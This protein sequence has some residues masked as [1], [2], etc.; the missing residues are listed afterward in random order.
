M[1]VAPC[2][3]SALFVAALLAAE[4]P[5]KPTHKL[6]LADYFGPFLAKKLNDCRTCHLPDT[7]D[8]ESEKPH[9]AFGAKLAELRAKLKQ[10]GKKYDIPICLEAIAN[11][12]SDGDGVS[13]IVELLSGHFPGDA[14]DKPTAEEIAKIEKTLAAFRK[15]QAGYPWRPFEPVNRP[16]IPEVKN[17][18]WVRN[19]IDAFITAGHEQEGITPRPEAPRPVLLRRVYLDLFGLPPTR[20]ELRAFLND[21]SA[22][23]YEKVVERLLASPQYGERWGRHWMD[24][25]RYSDWAG[26]GAEV[27]DSQPHVWRWRDWIVESLNADKGYDRMIQEMLAGDELAPEDPDI[28]R[29]TGYLVRNYK[30]YSR[31]RWMQDTVEHTFMAFQAVTLQCAR[32][33]DHMYDPIEQSEYYGVRA[34]FEPYQVRIDRLPGQPDLAKDGLARAYDADLK[35]ITYLFVRGDDR[36]PDKSKPLEPSVPAALGGKLATEPV[37]LPLSAHTPD[38][39][40]FVMRELVESLEKSL[41]LHDRDVTN[42]ERAPWL[43]HL[44]LTPNGGP[45]AAVARLGMQPGV[46]ALKQ[47]S[48]MAREAGVEAVR[49]NRLIA[50]VERLEDAGRSG[51]PEWATVAQDLVASERRLAHLTARNR[52]FGFKNGL[53][54]PDPKSKSTPQQQLAEAEKG[55][56]KAEAELKLPPSTQYTKRA[57]TTYPQTS[58]GRRLAFARWLSDS[59]NPLTARVAA[60]HIWLRHFGSAIAPSVFDFGKNGRLPSHPA[61]LDWLA[62]ELMSPTTPPDGGSASAWSMKHLHRLIVTS[63][64]YRQGSTPEPGNL[65]KDPDNIYYWRMLPHRL[66]AEVVRDSVFFVAGRLDGRMGGPDLDHALGLTAPR[67]SLYFRHAAEKQMEFLKLFDA[68]SVTEC[69][70]RR[71]SIMPQQALALANSGLVIEHARILA[72][73]L[74][75]ETGSDNGA[76]V[77]AAFETVLARPATEA[78][79]A[80]C[81]AFLEKQTQTHTLSADKTADGA[82]PG[83]KAPS[84]EPATRARENLV[85]VLM[86]HHDFVTVR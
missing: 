43:A 67:R 32:C 35:A 53:T 72:R 12:D 59:R 58:S 80:E 40:Q 22:D 48:V 37:N 21:P 50:E 63:A 81:T 66:E 52:H 79:L 27:R 74:A 71:D 26:W 7:D 65:A 8:D 30:R 49:K 55:L 84:S 1:R 64:T 9:N 57:V 78:E 38:R 54:H 18:A 75:A 44:V 4:A 56:G 39:R 42:T 25:W 76:F 62:S 60:N 17:K 15:Y 10:D 85:H 68:A 86:N 29:A 82:D 14:K 13:N 83:G 3:G 24:V 19:P 70:Q 61:L 11:D 69:Y 46:E 34:I 5:A 6:A 33:H 77:K 36:N 73:K 28:E 23:A 2:F 47:A 51:S 20:E 41:P 16:P 45:L 31:E